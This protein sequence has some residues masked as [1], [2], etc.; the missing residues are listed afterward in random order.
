MPLLDVVIV[1]IIAGVL[2]YLVNNFIPMASGIKSI[3][4]AVVCI[5]LV[6]WVLQAFGL[7]SSVSHF[8]VG[9]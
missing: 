6:V 7:W 3:L 5:A 8:R 1:L 2:M 4:N 9:R